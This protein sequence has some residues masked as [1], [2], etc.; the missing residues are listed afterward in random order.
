MDF[1]P[2]VSAV[3]VSHIEIDAETKALL[4]SLDIKD[5]PG[6]SVSAVSR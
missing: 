6:V 3:D 2:E 5:L 4:D 1:I